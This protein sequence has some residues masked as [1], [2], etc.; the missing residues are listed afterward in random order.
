MA[1][2]N[3]QK[4]TLEDFPEQRD[5][6][7]KLFSP[8]NQFLGDVVR[9]FNNGFTIEE[10]LYQE[11]REIKFKNS[12]NNFPYKFKTKFNSIP[13][14]LVS[15]YLFNNTTGSYSSQTPLVVWSYAEQEVSISQISGLT[16][17]VNYTIRVLL[18]YG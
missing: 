16:T 10:N 13:K 8:L 1:K 14:G 18:I 9:A 12:T 11:I 6:L 3:P 5:W 2:V 15:I 7:G 17:D 4:F